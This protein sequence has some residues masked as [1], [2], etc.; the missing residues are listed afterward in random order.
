MTINRSELA[1]E[2]I[3]E[4]GA[5]VL[6]Y[7][8]RVKSWKKKDSTPLSEADLIADRIIC[9]SI[10]NYFP[11]DGILSEERETSINRLSKE[12]T[13]IIDPIDGTANFIRGENDFCLMIGII[14][15]SIPFFGV[16]Y[17]PTEDKLF[18]GGY[19]S[20]AQLI[21]NKKKL[22]ISLPKKS[23]NVI[24]TS[25]DYFDKNLTAFFMEHNLKAISLGSAGVKI[26]GLLS[27]KGQ[28]YIHISDVKEWD[29][30]APEAIYNS[31][32]G[33]ITNRWGQTNLYNK[34][35]PIIEG[36][37]VTENDQIRYDAIKFFKF[38]NKNKKLKKKLL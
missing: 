15:D 2:L 10:S 7:F 14:K 18:Y 24:L 38:L 20:P 26:C 19:Q 37:L 32:G 35:E 31:L 3:Y 4:A 21:I 12:F 5:E 1:I 17:I 28:H 34:V 11:Q 22:P 30:A 8:G 9:E 29:T 6:K 23:G 36:I 16:I 13:W 33:K 25:K 27:N